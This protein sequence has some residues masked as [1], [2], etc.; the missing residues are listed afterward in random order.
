[1]SNK[2]KN[3]KGEHLEL[4]SELGKGGAATV[5]LHRHNTT[6][7][8]KIFKPHILNKEVNL[9]KRIEKLQQLSS[10]VDITMQFGN[11][12]KTIGAWP[13]DTVYDSMGTLVG[14]VMDTVN[15]G[16]DLSHI[17]MARDSKTAFYALRNEKHYSSWVNNFVYEPKNLRNR[18]ILAYYLSV[19][20]GKIYNLKNTSGIDIDVEICNFDIKPQNILVSLEEMGIEKD[21]HIV[22]YIL[23]L[24][25]LTLRSK[26]TTLA[27]S[28]IQT[29]PEYFASEGPIDK[30]YD[31]YSIAVIFHQLILDL[32]PFMFLNANGTRYREGTQFF[33]FRDNKCYPWGRNRKF[34]DPKLQNDVKWGNFTKL[35]PDIQQLFLR[36]FDCDKPNQRPSMNEWSNALASFIQDKNISFEK[37]FNISK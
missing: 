37:L 22:P 35:H 23:D 18:F 25:N 10:T 4:G 24:D 32:H 36:A 16:I 2:F 20:F 13:K 1:M 7:A 19:Y 33:F 28:S 29:T 34:L 14:Y 12:I 9:A 6:K 15:D 26:T 11:H 8:I 31:Y 27:P 5:Y 21:L 3:S 17:V 30:H